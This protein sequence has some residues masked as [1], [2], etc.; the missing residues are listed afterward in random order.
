MLKSGTTTSLTLRNPNAT[1]R[2]AGHGL[3][4]KLGFEPR[5]NVQSRVTICRLFEHDDLTGNCSNERE[6]SAGGD[7]R[8]CGARSPPLSDC[9][10]STLC[11]E[12]RQDARKNRVHFSNAMGLLKAHACI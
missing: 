3:P 5:T 6:R 7:G 11:S 9:T 4:G 8:R 12:K 10:T 1:S 2:K